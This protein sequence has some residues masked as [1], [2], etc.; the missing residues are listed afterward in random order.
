MIKTNMKRHGFTLIELVAVMATVSVVMGITAVLLVQLFDYQRN[1]AE[2]SER[3][4]AINRLVAEFR[5]DVRTYGKPEILTDG[6]TLLRW[7]TETK[8]IEYMAQPG[9]F[10]DQWSVVRTVQNEGT[11][12]RSETYH[13]PDR[14]TVRFAEGT[15][16]DA[17]LIALSLWTA[18]QG[19]AVLN[20]AVPNL[21]EPNLSELNPF[22]RTL[23]Q[24]LEQQIDPKYAGNLRT[25]IVRYLL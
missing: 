18:P 25:I 10:P 13:L 14:T 15:G 22:D 9:E 21:T 3:M 16:N 6:D 1:L 24:T 4:H 17:G 8:T 5:N 7:T 19:T 20:H 23:S 11:N 12:N 2:Y